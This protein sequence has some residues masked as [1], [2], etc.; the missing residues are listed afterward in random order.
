M[1]NV[2]DYMNHVCDVKVGL[3]FILFFVLSCHQISA[4]KTF[5]DT[6][7]IPVEWEGNRTDEVDDGEFIRR[8]DIKHVVFPPTLSLIGYSAFQ[9]C[10]NLMSVTIPDG[11][12]T[13]YNYAFWHC[14]ALQAINIPASVTKIGENAFP[15]DATLIVEKGSYAETFAKTRGMD[16][17]YTSNQKTSRITQLIQPILKTQWDQPLDYFYGR[18]GKYGTC[19]DTDKMG[20]CYVIAYGQI[21]KHLGLNLS[22]NIC[23]ATSDNIYFADL[24]KNKV[25]LNKVSSYFD[26]DSVADKET[27]TYIENIALA[28]EHAWREEEH[29]G[30]YQMINEHAPVKKEIYYLKEE[31]KEK[32]ERIIR[33]SLKKNI[34]LYTSLVGAGPGH[35]V[36]IDGIRKKN[37]ITEVH[38]NFG[39]GGSDNRWTTLQALINIRGNHKY[40]GVEYIEKLTPL[41]GKELKAWKPFCLTA[42][43]LENVKNERAH[44]AEK[45]HDTLYIPEGTKTIP[46]Y[47]NRFLKDSTIKHISLPSTLRELRKNHMNLS[48]VEELN[49]PQH[50]N[51]IHKSFFTD[52]KELKKITF[53][54]AEKCWCEERA[55]GRCRNLSTIEFGPNVKRVP[56]RLLYYNSRVKQIIWS[57]SIETIGYA[58]FYQAH[59]KD[60]TLPTHVKEI[61]DFGLYSD[62]INS[63]TVP[64]SVQ[65]ID[66]NSFSKRTTIK[67]RKDSY[68]Y[69]WAKRNKRKIEVISY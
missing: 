16:Y 37:G 38:M 57:K 11:C 2:R 8:F 24:D 48:N 15:L 28:L 31:G 26:K 43:Q 5:G 36:V 9:D 33:K 49:L 27:Y 25:D 46:P 30:S 56:D 19:E 44:T 41:K 3:L 34:P 65:K 52:M 62:Y 42:E 18:N 68:A 39:W 35:A 53:N 7:N 13:I 12:S 4:K 40:H 64:N 54:S 32:L 20:I 45:R 29:E 23:Y 51:W 17:Q 60:L 58:S 50:V 22:G 21:L 14:T 66:K 47:H 59:I 1:R 55:F 69:K 63:I 61:E 10:R 6:L 67:C